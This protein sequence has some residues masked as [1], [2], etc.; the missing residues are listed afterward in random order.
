MSWQTVSLEELCSFENGDRGKNYPGKSSHVE[1]GVPFVSAGDLAGGRI[2]DSGLSFISDDHYNRLSNGKFQKGDFL[3]CLRG[4]LGK[5][6]YVDREIH[7]AIASSLIIIRPGEELHP[8]YFRAYLN[9]DQ[10]VRQIDL[11]R[12]GAAQPNLSAAS[13]KKFEIPLPSLDEQK[14]IAA[15]LDQADALRRMRQRAIDR[16]NTLGQAIFYEMFGDPMDDPKQHLNW[17]AEPLDESVHFIDYRGKT[18]PKTEAGIPLITAKNVKM[19]FIRRDPQE[20]IDAS[21]YDTWMN[22]GFPKK[23]DILFTTEAPLGNVA[24]LNTDEKL[25]V[26][27]RLL[28]LQPAQAKID[29]IYLMYFLMSQGFRRL[30]FENSTGSTVVGIKSKLLKKIPIAYPEIDD[31][32]RFRDRVKQVGRLQNF[33]ED[34][35]ANTDALF[36]S[37]QQRAFRGEL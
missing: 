1:F 27:Q 4:T 25:V 13:L 12:N 21:A 37:L 31:Q 3:F 8:N 36:S 32:V 28:T 15:I 20:Y 34:S 16:L 17:R 6:A 24:E 7:G 2:N 33:A 22:R 9:S 14:R 35:V 10:C 30:M 19:G 18:P 29:P 11:F 26:G 23:G 5:S